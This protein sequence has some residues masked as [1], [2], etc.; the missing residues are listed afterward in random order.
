LPDSWRGVLQ[1][2]PRHANDAH[3]KIRSPADRSKRKL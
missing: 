3:N 1:P 2:I